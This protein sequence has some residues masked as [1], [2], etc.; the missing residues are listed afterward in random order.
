MPFDGI[1]FADAAILRA[2]RNG[3][4]V[5]ERWTQL[6]A[7]IQL[8][9]GPAHCVIGWIEVAGASSA[10]DVDRIV[11]CHLYPELPWHRRVGSDVGTIG[12]PRVAAVIAFQDAW[13]R[14][15]ATVVRLFDR[16][17]ARLNPQGA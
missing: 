2:A 11:A 12:D 8:S 17:L 10:A 13:W 4:A 14:R 1:E 5:R 15:H 16:A 9:S 3:I 6:R 7:S